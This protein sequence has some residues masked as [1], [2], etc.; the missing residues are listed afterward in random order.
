MKKNIYL[1]AA[2]LLLNLAA[3][4]SHAATAAASLPDKLTKEAVAAM[5]PEEKQA[6]LE[7]I[8]QRVE[9]IKALDKSTMTREERKAYRAELKEMKQESKLIDPSLYIIGAIIVALVIILLIIF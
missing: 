9:A 7:E 2:I 5:T 3:F 1:A 4:S 8:K 6:R